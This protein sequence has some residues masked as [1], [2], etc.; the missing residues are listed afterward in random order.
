MYHAPDASHRCGN[1]RGCLRGTREGVLWEIEHWLAGKKDQPVFWLNGLAGTGKSTIAQTF[2]ETTFADGKLGASFFCSRDFEDRSNL[3]M[4]FPT[5]A[6]QLAYHYPLFRKELFQVLKANPD[7]GQESLCSQ[8]EN[9][10]VGPL[11]TTCISTLIIIDA[12]DECK[13]EEPASAILSILSRCSSEIPSV[14]FFITGRPEPRIRSGFR[15][16]SLVPI[17]EVFKLHEVKPEAVDSDI[18]LFLQTQLTGLAKN[19]SDCDLMED[20]PS[21]SDIKI[22]CKKAAGFFIYASTVVKFI[23]SESDLPTE[24]LALITSLPQNTTEEGKSGVDQLY[25]RVLEQAFHDGHADNS[26]CYSRFQNVVGTVMLIFNPL[27]IKSLSKLL[28]HHP[29]HIRSAIRSLHSLLLVP[30]TIEGPVLTFHKSFPDFLTD[31]ERCEDKRFLVEPMVHHARIL[32]SCLNLMRERLKKNICNL[33]DCAILNEVK[34]LP[35]LQREHIGDA[36]EYACHFWTKHLLKIPSNSSCVEEVQK[37]IN[38]F[39]TLCLPYWIEVLALTGNLGVGVYAMNDVEKWYTLVS[40]VIDCSLRPMFTLIQL[41]IPCK[42]ATDSQRLILENF[43]MIHDSPSHTYHSAIP[44]S[45]SSSWLHQCY[46]AELLQEV[47]VV[48]GLPAK[49][50][51]C[52]RTVVLDSNPRALACW[53]DTIAVGLQSYDI[54]FLDP[55]MGGQKVIFSGH[56]GLVGSLAFSL[57]GKLLASGGHDKAIN[58][59]D[60]QTGG[61]IKTFY[62]HTDYIHS[63][64]ISSDCTT[65]VSGAMDREI[66]LWEIQTGECYHI[67]KQSGAVTCVSFSPTNPQRLVSASGGKVQHWNIDGR[68]IGPTYDGSHAAFSSDGAQFVL[69]QGA[70]VIVCDTDSGRIMTKFLGADS[71]FEHCCFSPDGGSIA[72]AA[73][74]TIYV[75]DITSFNPCLVGTFVGHTS[76]IS[77]L[78]FS[79]SLISTSYDMSVRFW[80]ICASSM[81]SATSDPKPKPLSLAPIKSITLH[82]QDSFVISSDSDGVVKT[83]DILTGHCRATFQTPG[84]GPGQGNVQLV[85]GRLTSVW[86]ADQKIN[87]WDVE[88]G[89]LLQSVDAPGHKVEGVRISGDGSKVFCLSMTSIQAWSILTGEVMGEVGF[90]GLIPGDSLTVDGSRIWVC[91][92]GLNPK[93]WDFGIS[94]SPPVPLSNTPLSRPHLGIRGWGP[95]P[96]KIKNPVTGKEVLQLSGKFTKPID[97]WWDDQ[98]LVAGYYSGEVLILDFSHTFP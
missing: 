86:W 56:T 50:G 43:D 74:Y 38:E 75:W 89:E 34:N 90:G 33:D 2:A 91:F 87:I 27:S 72:V 7:A 61:I 62:G 5:L 9:L 36:L 68:R 77:S 53:R 93:G 55:I 31:P 13:D 66:R 60:I 24:R 95:H 40:P 84:R 42:W 29:S 45:P 57:D 12:L 82:T 63:I 21:S 20:W 70:A 59:W 79:S 65:I 69:C 51:A 80:Q 18:K 22:L 94:G 6:F 3:Q 71:K 88:K 35:T 98:Y 73:G 46:T 49:W 54:V 41:G 81:H 28:K 76:Y 64:S 39:F 83:W 14:K 96:S 8:M 92:P 16:E 17:T 10:L 19:R 37:A 1:R 47:K 85:N 67:I 26:Q 32:L 58:L 25:L 4:I 30:D 48:M 15:L 44:F 78:M 11:K 97:A 52:T 23:A